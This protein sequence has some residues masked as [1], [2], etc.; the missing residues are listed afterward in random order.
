M[1]TNA[2]TVISAACALLLTTACGGPRPPIATLPGVGPEPAKTPPSSTTPGLPTVGWQFFPAEQTSLWFHS[3][4]L[5]GLGMGGAPA[6]P[7]PLYRPGYL[8]EV[9]AAR[10]R[11]GG[12]ST[13]SQRAA[14]F[15]RTF[16]A[17]PNDYSGLQF[18]PLYF[19]TSQALFTAIDAWDRAQGDARS[20]TSQDAQR[21]LALLTSMF[22][23][24]VQ[25]RNVID[26]ARAV[27]DEQR[28]FFHAYWLEQQPRLAQLAIAARTDWNGLLPQVTRF[29]EYAQ[30]HGGEVFLT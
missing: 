19:Q 30:V 26:F 6:G 20:A 2:R 16:A 25:R 11:L 4:A 10:R 18:L 3:L 22:P 8:E 24:N 5:V 12:T 28:A 14:E 13:L 7:V 15:E 17:N 27:Q 9:A 29:V 21:A 1:R 23:S